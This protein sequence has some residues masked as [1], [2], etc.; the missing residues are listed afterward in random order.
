MPKPPSLPDAMRRYLAEIDDHAARYRPNPF[1]EEQLAATRS[2]PAFA[3][4]ARGG[5]PDLDQ[6][7]QEGTAGYGFEALRPGLT[8]QDDAPTAE[9]LAALP[10]VAKRL[11]QLRPK[12]FGLGKHEHEHLMAL[13]FLAR[14]EMTGL[15]FAELTALGVRSSMSAA[16]HFFYAGLLHGLIAEVGL[17]PGPLDVC[18]VGAGAETSPAS[19]SGADWCGA[20]SSSTCRKW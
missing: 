4:L 20:T 5:D 19:S 7:F 17:S 8:A 10:S 13:H 11:G 3:A 9:L 15:Y 16:R 18:E 14:E 1:W 12:G 2:T 6:L